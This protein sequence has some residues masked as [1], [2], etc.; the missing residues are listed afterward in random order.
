ME[1]EFEAILSPHTASSMI[2]ET[3]IHVRWN[4]SED[5]AI[6]RIHK[7]VTAEPRK[8]TDFIEI[9][10]KSIDPEEAKLVSQGIAD[11]YIALRN[12]TERARTDK[13]L[14]TLDDELQRHGDLVNE[15]RAA[16]SVLIQQ[17]GT[18]YFEERT[19]NNFT[20]EEMHRKATEKLEDLEESREALDT[21]VQKIMEALEKELIG[22]VARMD[23]PEN[24]VT[25]LHRTALEKNQLLSPESSLTEQEKRALELEVAALK[26]KTKEE[27]HKLNDV[28]K[29]RLELVDK[30]IERLSKM[31]LEAK[32]FSADLSMRQHKYNSVREEYD[33]ARDLHREM[34]LQQQEQ[35]VL[36]RMPRSPVTIHERAK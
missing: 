32:T 18:P 1:K 21:S 24:T 33:Q 7:M 22:K 11:A 14:Q 5:E 20:E 27:T 4:L 34:K 9:T 31:N 16:L 6:E 2:K 35:R 36:L 17:Y 26:K 29:A 12:A 15:R 30:Q 28:L 10:A 23:L 13:A 25:E 3:D 8:G 19:N